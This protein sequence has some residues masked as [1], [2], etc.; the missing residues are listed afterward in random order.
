[1]K[2]AQAEPHRVIA[3]GEQREQTEIKM[4]TADAKRS[5]D[6]RYGETL[7]NP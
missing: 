2:K 4:P 1:M 7:N 5:T 3:I 6:E